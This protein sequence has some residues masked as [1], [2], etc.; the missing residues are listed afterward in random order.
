MTA[1]QAVLAKMEEMFRERPW[2][3]VASREE[4]LEYSLRYRAHLSHSDRALYNE[5]ILRGH[6]PS[7]VQ[8]MLERLRN[9][10][11]LSSVEE[12]LLAE[13]L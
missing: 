9:A 7:H 4:A 5:H 2:C 6:H 8:E 1:N 3:G 10:G 12:P 13:A 11:M